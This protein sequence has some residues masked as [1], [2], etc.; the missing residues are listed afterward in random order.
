MGTGVADIRTI[1]VNTEMDALLLENNLIEAPAAVQRQPEGRQDPSVDLHP[2]RAFLASF[3]TRKMIR[4]GSNI[5][6]V[7]FRPFD[8]YVAGAD[9]QVVQA[10]DVQPALSEE[11]SERKNSVS[12]YQIG[13]RDLVG[14]SILGRVRSIW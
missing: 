4:D 6:T 13:C 3:S 10:A 2:Q 1:V 11:K 8:Q 14:I 12:A 9:Q 5:S 7:C